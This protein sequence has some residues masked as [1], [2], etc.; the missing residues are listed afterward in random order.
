M[1]TTKLCKSDGKGKLRKCKHSIS[2]TVRV[3]PPATSASSVP[4]SSQD[5]EATDVQQVRRNAPDLS[6]GAHT[7]APL[8]D[9]SSIE[10]AI[11]DAKNAST[12]IKPGPLDPLLTKVSKF[13]Q[14]VDRVAEVCFVMQMHTMFGGLIHVFS[15]THMQR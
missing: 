8:A 15:Y 1:V 7:Q 13:T 11:A 2:F 6:M 10:M 12:A 4:P 14:L 3:E 5:V 9:L